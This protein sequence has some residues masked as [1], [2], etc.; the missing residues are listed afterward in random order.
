M[1][2]IFHMSPTAIIAHQ[3]QEKLS[4]VSHTVLK[5]QVV[6]HTGNLGVLC[7][8][9]H[10]KMIGTNHVIAEKYHFTLKV[11]YSNIVIAKYFSHKHIPRRL[12]QQI[13]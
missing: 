10:L 12:Y 8:H 5:C 1:Q 13:T 4:Q 9:G 2:H 11:C 7:A 3:A 6:R